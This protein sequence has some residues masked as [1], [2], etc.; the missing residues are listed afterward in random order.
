ME[1]IGR[2]YMFITSTSKQVRTTRWPTIIEA[3]NSYKK[4]YNFNSLPWLINNSAHRIFSKAVLLMF[5]SRK[6]IG[7]DHEINMYTPSK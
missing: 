1:I 3:Q 7:S 4:I 5:S 6:I 2:C